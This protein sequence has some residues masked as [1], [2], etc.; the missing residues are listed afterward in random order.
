[1]RLDRLDQHNK[2]ITQK[3]NTRGQKYRYLDHVPMPLLIA[4]G[5]HLVVEY[6]NGQ[7]LNLIQSISGDVIGRRLPEILPTVFSPD[8]VEEVHRYIQRGARRLLNEK[9]IIVPSPGDPNRLWFNVDINPIREDEGRL[10]D[11]IVSF[12]DVT[13]QVIAKRS[14]AQPTEYL[15]NFFREAPVG[16]VCYRGP[17]FIVDLANDRALKMWGKSLDEVIGKRIDEIFPEVKTDPEI[18]ARHLESLER[19]KKGE[20]HFVNEVE[21]TFPRNGIPQTGWYSYIHEPYRDATGEIIGMMA[22]AIDVTEQVLSRK[23][24]EKRL[25]EFNQKL[26]A[27]VRERTM[28]LTRTNDL[29]RA[30]I[31]ELNDTQAVLQQLIDS[32]VEYIAVVDRDLRFLVVNKPLERFMNR[33][34][35]DLIGKHIL[36]AY[37]RA[38][39]SGQVAALERA[40]AGEVVHLRVNPSISRPNVWF[41]THYV[42]LVIGGRVDG[43]IALSRD[44]S[45]IV[46]SEQELAKLNRQLAEAQRLAKLGSWEWDVASGNVLWSDEMYRIYGYDEKFPV[47]FVRATER[48]SPQDAETSSRRTQQH[49]Q[50]AIDQFNRNGQLV[51]EISSIEFPIKLPD[52]TQKILRN[53]GKIQLTSD[54]KLHRILGVVQDVT[55]IR[56]TEEQLLLLV[57]ELELKNKELESFNYVAS[58]DLQEP[59]RK[60]QT[61]IDRIRNESPDEKTVDNY[62]V[63]IDNSARRMHDLIQSMLAWSRLSNAS[64]G[65]TDVDLN[66]VLG[67]CKSDLELVIKEKHATIESDILPIVAASAFQMNQLFGNLLSNALKFSNKRPHLRIVCKK[68]MDRDV[69]HPKAD[70]RKAYWCISFLDNGIGFDSKYKEQIF[71][72]FQRLHPKDDFTGTGIGLSIVKRIVERHLGFVDVSS[73]P[74]RGS[75]FSIWLP[76]ETE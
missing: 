14:I 75:C 74:G 4:S 7:A 8:V 24:S 34:H 57:R 63:R 71:E 5:D 10:F 65:F 9:Q 3:E 52:G 50:L 64:D 38:R 47:D 54:G 33:S 40:L 22:L 31:A 72:L 49:I 55:H 20:P 26:E 18:N 13:H 11:V 67:N 41:D 28:E 1:M 17:E 19:L 62:L 53:T 58:H 27:D 35:G 23:M 61:F 70:N 69:D 51:F 68:V 12:D 56:S 73:E 66:T 15:G 45:E 37:E 16:L 39:G 59:L 42:P 21:L 46:K 30:K 32:S 2:M 48:M 6:A 25:T 76:C 44:I 36:E 43:V 60:I 29:L